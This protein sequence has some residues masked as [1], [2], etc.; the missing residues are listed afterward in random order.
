MIKMVSVSHLAYKGICQK[1]NYVS[2]VEKMIAS[3]KFGVISLAF[4]CFIKKFHLSSF[5]TLSKT[6]D[7]NLQCLLFLCNKASG[8]SSNNAGWQLGYW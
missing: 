2:R 8:L 4:D 3:D 5:L 6:D 7:G 1:Q